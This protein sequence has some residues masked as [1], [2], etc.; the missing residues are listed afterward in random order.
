[1]KKLFQGEA[2]EKEEKRNGKICNI[3]NMIEINPNI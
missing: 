1:M 3:N 2:K